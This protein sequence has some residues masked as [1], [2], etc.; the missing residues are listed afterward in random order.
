[1]TDDDEARGVS[2][3]RV[4]LQLRKCGSMPAETTVLVSGE[5]AEWGVIIDGVPVPASDIASIQW[6]ISGNN[7][8]PLGG[9]QY[10][11][12]SCTY[13]PASPQTYPLALAM[14]PTVFDQPIFEGDL[15]AEGVLVGANAENFSAS[16]E[17]KITVPGA[18]SV[19]AV[20][21]NVQLSVLPNGWIDFELTGTGGV[22]CAIVLSLDVDS[23]TTGSIYVVQLVNADRSYQDAQGNVVDMTTTNGQWWYDG[24]NYPYPYTI[25][26]I[27]GQGVYVSSFTDSPGLSFNPDDFPGCVFTMN[28]RF[29]TYLM[30]CS[31]VENSVP[32][33]LGPPLTWGYDASFAYDTKAGAWTWTTPPTLYQPTLG[34]TSVP[35]SWTQNMPEMVM[36]VRP[37][38]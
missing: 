12:V 5:M 25:K 9:C 15:L 31:D 2:S 28:D 17:M 20:Y 16:H 18:S 1:M 13:Q 14:V 36:R 34:I 23:Q 6:T 30:F 3:D 7:M 21:G 26:T 33:I 29:E 27:N 4:Q 8:L 22:G 24:D 19:S 38:A 32:I 37:R 11:A 35:P 10:A